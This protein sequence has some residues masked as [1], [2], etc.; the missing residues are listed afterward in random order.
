MRW[1]VTWRTV[2]GSARFGQGASCRGKSNNHVAG[3][4]V[5]GG[6]AGA[7]DADVVGIVEKLV[8]A[9]APAAED[10]EDAVEGAAAVE[11]EF[12]GFEELGFLGG[13]DGGHGFGIQRIEPL[14]VAIRLGGDEDELLIRQAES[15]AGALFGLV[16]E[17]GNPDDRVFADDFEGRGAG[18]GLVGR[19]DLRVKVIPV[20]LADV[21]GENAA[22]DGSIGRAAGDE[23]VHAWSAEVDRPC[24]GFRPWAGDKVKGEHGQRVLEHEV[25]LGR[26]ADAMLHKVE[27]VV[28]VDGGEFSAQDERV[29]LADEYGFDGG[30]V[31]DGVH[32][33]AG[34]ACVSEWSRM[35]L[36][37]VIFRRWLPTTHR[38][39]P[40]LFFA[41]R[42][43]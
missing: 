29:A 38:V 39:T 18:F 6:A 40:P 42:S 23:E 9:V 14:H 31:F 20:R 5:V 17:L 25:E 16:V 24:A 10:R 43:A 27:I 3:D 33:E 4:L 22:R 11:A 21:L 28:R 41:L 37:P 34:W 35:P 1:R 7:L 32:E 8:E 26:V 13:I 2:K 30:E 19:G 36:C 15:A 12:P